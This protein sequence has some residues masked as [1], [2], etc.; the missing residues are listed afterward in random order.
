MKSVN[1][2]T[3]DSL[4]TAVGRRKITVL[5]GGISAERE[6]SLLTGQAALQAL[7]GLHLNVEGLDIK[8]GEDFFTL[9]AS[10][11]DAALICLHG[12][13]GEDGAVQGLL[14]WLGIPY[15]GS[16]ILASALAMDKARS[17]QLFRDLGL[18]TSPWV[19][20]TD[21]G[22]EIPESFQLPLV[23][24]PN[25]QGSA[26]G[27]SIVRTPEALAD[28]L[29]QGRRYDNQILVET[30]CPGTEISVAVLGGQALPVI[31]IVPKKSFYDYEAKY[32]QGM[33]D[34]I[35]PAR[36]TPEATAYA[37]KLAVDAYRGLDCR[38]AARVDIII[39][40]EGGMNILEV[41][42]IPGMTSTSLLPDAA[43]HAGIGFESLVLMLI[44][45][46]LGIRL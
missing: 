4:V 3:L 26:I 8:K 12:T 18:P 20:L 13:G 35:I 40:P 45:E 36:L 11:P 5:M 25:R 32:V 15:T 44:L 34:H 39:G 41:N 37:Q 28:A 19:L 14:Q 33:A 43:R 23:I 31:E 38:G 1:L 42:T 6:I 29:F 2:P 27:V 22:Q 21:P 16:G 46:A 10:K 7:Q 24:K 30:F 17:K 9:T